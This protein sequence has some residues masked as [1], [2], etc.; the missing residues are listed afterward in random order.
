VL[1]A[2]STRM[3]DAILAD[4]L[5]QLGVGQTTRIAPLPGQDC[6]RSLT[7]WARHLAYKV[8]STICG[9]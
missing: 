4:L 5:C 6:N 9:S 8:I 7:L 2:K 1:P 3:S